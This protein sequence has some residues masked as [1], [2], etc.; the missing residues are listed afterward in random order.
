MDVSGQTAV[1]IMFSQPELIDD[2]E[3]R[4]TAHLGAIDIFGKEIQ[5]PVECHRHDPDRL[6]IFGW[7]VE[8]FGSR[9]GGCHDRLQ[10]ISL[11]K[12]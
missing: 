5:H 2:K 8:I 9:F 7:G 4:F 10:K 6:G 12:P 1:G 3:R 11:Q